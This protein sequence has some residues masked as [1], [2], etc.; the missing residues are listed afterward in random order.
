MG[1]TLGNMAKMLTLGIAQARLDKLLTFDKLNASIRLH[2]CF[3]PYRAP[4]P[5]ITNPGRCPGLLVY[6]PFRP[7][8]GCLC[9]YQP[10]ALPWA[11]GLLAFQA[12]LWLSIL[13][14]LRS[15]KMTED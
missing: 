11:I 1:M 2:Q 8:Y 6:W 9:H 10:W 15:S 4:I 7:F 5:A 12:V 13:K 14:S 3:C